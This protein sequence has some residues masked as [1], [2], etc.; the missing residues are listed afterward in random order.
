M[1]TAQKE[2]NQ[3]IL[4]SVV[5]RPPTM[6]SLEKV[7]HSIDGLRERMQG[8][9]VEQLSEIESR[10]HAMSLRLGGLQRTVNALSDVKRR[11][12]RIEEILKQAQPVTLG[13]STLVTIDSM[14]PV[15]A[16]AHLGNL[17]KFR[18]IIKLV[19]AAKSI[20]LLLDSGSGDTR[21]PVLESTDA[22]AE[23]PNLDQGIA[24]TT[25]EV[26]LLEPAQN[27]AI[28]S[29]AS[30]AAE[31]S[32]PAQSFVASHIQGMPTEPG[33]DEPGDIIPADETALPSQWNE[34]NGE[35]ID[36]RTEDPAP[37]DAVLVESS[38][39]RRQAHTTGVE[40]FNFD[41]QL[42]DDLIRNYGEFNVLPSL[43]AK[44]QPAKEDKHEAPISLPRPESLT[45]LNPASHRNL[46]APRKDGELDRKLKKLIKDYGEYDL[47]SRHSPVNLKTGIVAAFLVLALV[48]S[49][50]YFFSSPRSAVPAPNT[51]SAAPSQDKDT[52]NDETLSTGT[53][54]S[55]DVTKP[56]ETGAS[57]DLTNNI[58]TRKTK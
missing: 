14:A 52:A 55:I 23:P 45:K 30:E 44:A 53:A 58:A 20:S 54:S 22:V 38:T 11:M 13:E 6:H 46:A 24:G 8:F 29:T 17:V 33:S 15:H 56:V 21:T 7:V 4:N 27:S 12:N 37:S 9:S 57:R 28:V 49:G 35:F 36:A 47:Y 18:Q 43:P 10:L 40:E 42:L 16:L 39:S 19:K 5:Q 32:E 41:Q 2:N 50:F 26:P 51:S 1:L 25:M 48:F 34:I 31:N 3:I